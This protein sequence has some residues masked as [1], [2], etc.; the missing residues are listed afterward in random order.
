M[1]GV[2]ADN[3]HRLHYIEKKPKDHD[4]FY[5][6]VSADLPIK[7]LVVVA[8]T[9]IKSGHQV[10]IWTGRRERCR[11]DTTMWLDRQ[12]LS[13]VSKIRMRADDDLR[14][15]RIVK[16]EWVE[17][18][19]PCEKPHLA[20]DDMPDIVAMYRDAGILCCQTLPDSNWG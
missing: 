4:S 18:C 12:G 16:R 8:R 5:A 15:T 11:R 10:E 6:N 2:L 19:F 3:R 1:D 20:F 17:S 13:E 7:P 14:P 9:M